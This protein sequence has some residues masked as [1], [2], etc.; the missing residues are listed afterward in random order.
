MI[1]KEVY[2]IAPDK[3]VFNSKEFKT[4]SKISSG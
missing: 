2:N 4:H 3:F 1:I